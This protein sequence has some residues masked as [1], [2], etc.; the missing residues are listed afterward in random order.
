MK[1]YEANWPDGIQCKTSVHVGT[2]QSI[3][4]G[5]ALINWRAHFWCSQI[6]RLK[7]TMDHKEFLA[8]MRE[9]MAMQ[10][11]SK[12]DQQK[13]DYMKKDREI[14]AHAKELTDSINEL[15]TTKTGLEAEVAEFR[16]LKL[17]IQ[18]EMGKNEDK[19]RLF[20]KIKRD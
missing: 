5:N 2:C 13:E 4:N 12:L 19:F 17:S 3:V 16:R 6:S 11:R 18:N 20:I 15:Q 14:L 8:T 1:L 7:T 10:L 9:H